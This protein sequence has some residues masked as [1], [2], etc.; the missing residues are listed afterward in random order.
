MRAR[1]LT[2]EQNREVKISKFLW[3]HYN[4]DVKAIALQKHGVQNTNFRFSTSKFQYIFRLYNFKTTSEIDY[5][6]RILQTLQENE[7][8][9]PRLVPTVNRELYS[10]FQKKPCFVYEYIPGKNL[11]KTSIDLIKQIGKLQA[12]MHC[13][14]ANEKQNSNDIGWDFDKLKYLITKK[15]DTVLQSGFPS[16]LMRLGFINR[17]LEK[18]NFPAELPEGGT[19]QDIK[20]E[21]VIVCNGRVKGIVDFD[22]AYYGDLLHDITTTICWYCFSSSQ[23][24]LRLYEAFLS[25]YQQERSLHDLEKKYMYQGIQFRLLRE[26]VIW[27]MYVSHSIS[28]AKFYSDYFLNLYK[29]FHI[30]ETSIASIL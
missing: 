12:R 26:S 13:L 28:K 9:S 5:V 29:C 6:I 10:I 17:E 8:P 18:F 2:G 30:S 27:P 14:L 23:L 22:N 20:P 4:Q 24:N 11:Q 1:Q 15:K 16:A 3:E 19:H 7:F 25:S 21:N